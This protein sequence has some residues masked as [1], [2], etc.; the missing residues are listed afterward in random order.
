MNRPSF[1][2]SST[3]YDF[4]DIR[5]SIKF[6]LE[7]SGYSVL[8]S[9]F[10]D[11]PKELNQHSYKACLETIEKADYFILLIGSRVGGWY[12]KAEKISI[13]RQEYRIAYE[14]HKRGKLKLI[15]LVRKEVWQFREQ[16]KELSAYLEKSYADDKE[17]CGIANY[18]SKFANDAEAICNFIEEISRNLE[19]SKATNREAEFPSA[20]WVH[21]FDTF[22]DISDV[23]RTETFSG[24]PIDKLIFVKLLAR[25]LTEI[26]KSS[27][28]KYSKNLV[29][30][31]LKRILKFRESHIIEMDSRFKNTEVIGKE[32]RL[33][34]SLAISLLGVNISAQVLDRAIESPYFLKFNLQLNQYEE[35]PL[36]NAIY[37]LRKE[38]RTFNNTDKSEVLAVVFE[39]SPKNVGSNVENIS[40]ETIKLVKFIQLMDQWANIIQLS[41]SILRHLQGSPF[42]MPLIISGSPI[43]G[44]DEQI[45]KERV[46]DEDVELFLNEFNKA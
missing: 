32:W 13:T 44:M 4:R 3:I 6:F 29:L 9:E 2:L 42:V 41:A 5:S 12:D 21:T 36:Y 26:L 7:E 11:F 31:P 40:I 22:R 16:R 25:E 18:K 35:E 20:N 14:L 46:T 24:S 10:N 28:A 34:S 38:I 37:L 27:L 1:F 15:T 43:L 45:D 23:I 33:T 39:Y 19:T 8:A 30:S 17:I